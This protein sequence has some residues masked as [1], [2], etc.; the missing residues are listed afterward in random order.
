MPKE[1][2]YLE[3]VIHMVNTYPELQA[4]LERYQA[5]YEEEKENRQVAMQILRSQILTGEIM[6]EEMRLLQEELQLLRTT[7]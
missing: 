6:R 5:L 1:A 3:D 7:P 2:P 4:E